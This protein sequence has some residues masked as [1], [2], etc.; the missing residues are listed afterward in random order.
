MRYVAAVG[1]FLAA[2]FVFAQAQYED[3]LKSMLEV[4][5]R[6]VASLAKVQDAES[7]K[8]TTPELK[9]AASDFLEVRAKAGKMDPPNRE[10]KDRLAKEYQPKF[11]ESKKKLTAEIERLKRLPAGKEVLAEIRSILEPEKK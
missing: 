2:G 7:A 1:L 8:E 10:E 9:K 3:V 4:L 6:T 11:V 5:D